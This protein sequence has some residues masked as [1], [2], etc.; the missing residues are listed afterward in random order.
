MPATEWRTPAPQLGEFTSPNRRTNRAH[1]VVEE[2]PDGRWIPLCD[3]KA[4][5][6]SPML[7]S[8]GSEGNRCRNCARLVEGREQDPPENEY[9]AESRNAVLATIREGGQQT[10]GDIVAKHRGLAS[11][12]VRMILTRLVRSGDVR[13]VTRG[14]YVADDQGS[15]DGAE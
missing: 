4:M 11:A 9:W 12:N 6:F 3:A 14:V 5:Q 1:V 15:D 7:P 2:M 8:D 13:R 10:L